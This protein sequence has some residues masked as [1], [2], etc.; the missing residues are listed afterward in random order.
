MPSSPG[1]LPNFLIAGMMKSGTSALAAALSHHPDVWMP[2]RELHFFN[3]EDQYAK[4]ADAYRTCFGGWSGQVA[5]GEKTPIYGF[6]LE[7]AARIGNM[8]PDVKFIWILRE[9]VARTYSHY[10]FATAQGWEPYDFRRALAAEPRRLAEAR[11]NYLRANRAYL[12]LSRYADQIEPFLAWASADR[13]LFLLYADFV[14]APA[15]TLAQVFRFLEIDPTFPFP[16]PD[17]RVNET[18]R[19]YH[20]GLLW[21]AVQTPVYLLPRAVRF[22]YR[23]QKL[24]KMIGLRRTPGYPPLDEAYR[25]ELAAGFAADNRR[26]AQLTG[27]DLAAWSSA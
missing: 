21:L 3:R 19:P 6:H 9:P 23:V 7:A 11:P 22:Q 8:L 24:A 1:P 15:A 2:A 20:T 18:Y 10:W 14:R 27:L 13:H 16:A 12:T 5:V 4:G 26:L 17:C 25:R